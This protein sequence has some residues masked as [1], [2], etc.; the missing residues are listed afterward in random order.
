MA[1]SDS[2]HILPAGV[3]GNVELA[4]HLIQEGHIDNTGSSGLL[5]ANGRLRILRIV[6][7]G[8]R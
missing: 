1:L 4:K 5:M 6:T 2:Q 7:N 8:R 3:M